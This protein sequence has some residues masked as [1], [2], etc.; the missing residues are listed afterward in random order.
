MSCVRLGGV[1]GL[2]CGFFSAVVLFIEGKD[3]CG[4]EACLFAKVGNCLLKVLL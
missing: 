1:L 3:K 2:V 4:D